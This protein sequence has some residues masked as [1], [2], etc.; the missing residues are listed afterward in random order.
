MGYSSTAYE[1]AEAEV[2]SRRVRSETENR[3][4]IEKIEAEIPEIKE[5]N[6]QL[7]ETSV[8]L[9][10]L[11]LKHDGDMQKNLERLREN[12]LYCQ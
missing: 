4:R 8:D 2:N 12:N 5:L 3:M 11:I 9:A 6:R 1:R 7:S 10:K